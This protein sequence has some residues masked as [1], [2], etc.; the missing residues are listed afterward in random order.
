MNVR[1][2][3]PGV[4]QMASTVAE[5]ETVSRLTVALAAFAERI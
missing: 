1:E 5:P 3:A 2:T 4:V